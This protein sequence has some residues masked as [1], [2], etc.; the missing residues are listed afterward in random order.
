M[1]CHGFP[2]LAPVAAGCARLDRQHPVEQQHA[3]VGPRGQVSAAGSGQ[4]K[5][6][7]KLLEDVLQTARERV[8][9]GG[10]RERQPD[11]VARTRIGVLPDDE[12]PHLVEGL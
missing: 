10:D 3:L 6:R 5:I 9:I 1:C 11:R 2:T 12:D 4:A 7:P 8:D